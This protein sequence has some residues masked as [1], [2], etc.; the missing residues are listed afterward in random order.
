MYSAALAATSFTGPELEIIRDNK[1]RTRTAHLPAQP[2]H[3]SRKNPGD[4]L[5]GKRILDAVGVETFHDGDYACLRSSRSCLPRW[6]CL[7]LLTAV[8]QLV[9]YRRSRRAGI[10]RRMEGSCAGVAPAEVQCLFTA[11]CFV[12]KPD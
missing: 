1:N 5:V 11:H 9:L 6:A 7:L 10:W 3:Q 8:K 2:D 4:Y 12:N